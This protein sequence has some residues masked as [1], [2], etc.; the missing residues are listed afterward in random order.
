MLLAQLHQLAP[1]PWHVDLAVEA[2][3][4]WAADGH[5]V[6]IVD[7]WT[8][9]PDANVHVIASVIRVA[10]NEWAER[11]T[12]PK[13]SDGAPAI[14]AHVSEPW[15]SCRD[16]QCHGMNRC[17]AAPMPCSTRAKRASQAARRD[18]GGPFARLVRR[19]FQPATGSV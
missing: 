18:G 19:W 8:D 2:G 11:Q 5:Q 4:V 16:E 7:V 3:V 10:V 14:I 13:A 6:A 1:T 12:A 15:R 9:M 17:M